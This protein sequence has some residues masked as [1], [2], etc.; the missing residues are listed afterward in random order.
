[1]L[2]PKKQKVLVAL[3]SNP[4]REAAARACGISARTLYRL[5]HSDAEFRTALEAGRRAA[6][7][8][9]LH[10]LASTYP[11]AVETLRQTAANEQ[12]QDGARVAAARAIL[13]FGLKFSEAAD[14]EQRIAALEQQQGGFAD[15]IRNDA[16]PA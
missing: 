9:A 8:D 2:S 5:E 1:M 13:E 16:P 14:L 11:A 10:D 6:L 3:L 15:V 7:S 4:T 12:A